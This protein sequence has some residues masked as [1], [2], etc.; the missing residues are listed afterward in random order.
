MRKLLALIIAL[1]LITALTAC[2]DK[3]VL[4]DE[5]NS[6]QEWFDENKELIMAIYYP[7]D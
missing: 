1:V 4:Q 7:G 6:E 3:S 2:K 5:S